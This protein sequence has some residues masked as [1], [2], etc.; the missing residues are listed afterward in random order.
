MNKYDENGDFVNNQS[1]N[2][3]STYANKHDLP[4]ELKIKKIE[5]FSDRKIVFNTVVNMTNIMRSKFTAASL[6]PRVIRFY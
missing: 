4:F 6:E 2:S 1:F 3:L 5:D